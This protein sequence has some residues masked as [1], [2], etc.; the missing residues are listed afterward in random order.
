MI[1]S[2]P[3]VPVDV[4]CGVG[5]DVVVGWGVGDAVP[6]GP[7]VGS[8]P[9]AEFCGVGAPTAKSALLT[10]VLVCDALREMLVAFSVAEAGEPA[11][12]V[13]ESPQAT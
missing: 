8:A 2:V 5:V 4:G 3:G 7:G 13:A 1:V 12:G 6:V 9:E 11:A 10:A